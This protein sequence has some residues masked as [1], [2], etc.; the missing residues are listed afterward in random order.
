[1]KNRVELVKALEG[2]RKEFVEA[3]QKGNVKFSVERSELESKYR[4]VSGED[5]KINLIKK[6]RV[7]QKEKAKNKA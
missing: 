7:I 5:Y 4:L 3:L 2:M 1:M 6:E